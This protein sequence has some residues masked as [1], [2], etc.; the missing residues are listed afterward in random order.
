MGS[1]RQGS[2]C[3]DMEAE[4]SGEIFGLLEAVKGF[5]ASAMF[6]VTEPFNVGQHH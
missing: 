2:E 4:E 5:R 1:G 6:L 3:D